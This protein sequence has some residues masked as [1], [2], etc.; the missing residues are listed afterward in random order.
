MPLLVYFCK[1]FTCPF[2]EVDDAVINGPKINDN[3]SKKN[4][5]QFCL[6]V[7]HCLLHTSSY[8]SVFSL[9]TACPAWMQVSECYLSVPPR[10]WAS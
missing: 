8:L 3:F 9:S 7:Y 10:L 6:L 1:L 5:D 2:C 4:L